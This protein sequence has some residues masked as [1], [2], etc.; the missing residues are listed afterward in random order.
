MVGSGKERWDL[1]LEMETR[2]LGYISRTAERTLKLPAET[3]LPLLPLEA[4]VEAG[5]WCGPI[6]VARCVSSPTIFY[7]SVVRR[8]A[9]AR[10][11]ARTVSWAAVTPSLRSIASFCGPNWS[12]RHTT[13]QR[14]AP[15]P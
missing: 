11:F 1:Q 15:S 14:A 13:L 6:I 5:W 2:D 3:S 9:A 10:A 7:R 4:D 12:S 8:A